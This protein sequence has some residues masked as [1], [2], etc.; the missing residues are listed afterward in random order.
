MEM[1]QVSKWLV[2]FGL[3][4]AVFGGQLQGLPSVAPCLRLWR[5][6]FEQGGARVYVPIQ[7]MILASLFL[8]CVTWLVGVL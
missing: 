1:A 6:L 8:S 4:A 5:L 7:T 3:G 2:V